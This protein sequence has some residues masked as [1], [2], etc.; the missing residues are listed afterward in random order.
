M[1][2]RSTPSSRFPRA[3]P[4]AGR[5]RSR[6]TGS[7]RALKT[8]LGAPGALRADERGVAIA[9]VLLIGTIL[10]LVT[11]LGPLR[12]LALSNLTA[13]DFQW[14]Q[15][16]HVAESGVDVTLVELSGDP[17]YNTGDLAPTPFTDPASEKAW[18]I[19]AADAKPETH[20]Q[21]TPDGEYVVVKPHNA[22]VVYAVGYAPSRAATN[23]KLR[24]FRLDYSVV[25]SPGSTYTSEYAILT[26][27]NLDISGN[28]RLWGTNADAHANGTMFALKPWFHDGCETGYANQYVAGIGCP[29]LPIAYV[30]LPVVD[31][32]DAHYLSQYDVC[33]TGPQGAGIFK[34]PATA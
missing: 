33:A 10:V 21:Q 2:R 3:S 32:I 31:P 5:P 25:S 12:G 17:T 26:G 13:T 23:R 7:R 16:L 1:Q 14:E 34:G 20:V 22:D 27:G 15:A 8:L 6:S 18:V 24:V 19:G 4:I 30:P 11:I 29:P 28:A 9:V